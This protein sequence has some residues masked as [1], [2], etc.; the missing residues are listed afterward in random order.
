[1]KARRH[2]GLTDGRNC[3]TSRFCLDIPVLFSGRGRLHPN[4]PWPLIHSPLAILWNGQWC[5]SH[6]LCDHGLSSVQA[7]IHWSN[8][9]LK[10]RSVRSDL[11]L[12]RD[13]VT[14]WPLTTRP[15]TSNW[16]APAFPWC[17]ATHGSAA[18]N[19]IDYITERRSLSLLAL[20]L[21]QRLMLALC[22]LHP[23]QWRHMTSRTQYTH[24]SIMRNTL[25]KLETKHIHCSL[26]RQNMFNCKFTVI[27][28]R[29]VWYDVAIFNIGLKPPTQYRR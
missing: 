29:F 23:P 18:S 22:H 8:L 25:K 15:V 27:S 16:R 12:P 3:S 4:F 19:R 1:M 11:A 6:R 17:I 7:A 20:S 10:H 9:L 24:L 13:L 2:H 14:F 28:R 21:R 5:W 26:C